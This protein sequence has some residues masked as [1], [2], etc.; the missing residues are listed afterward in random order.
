MEFEAPIPICLDGEIKGAK[1][2][3]FTAIKNGF[4]FVVPRGSKFLS[5]S[6]EESK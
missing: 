4:N 3:E 2:V 6:S 5:C 1:S